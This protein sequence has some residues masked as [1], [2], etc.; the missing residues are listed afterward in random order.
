[1][2]AIC[3]RTFSRDA[4]ERFLDRSWMLERVAAPALNGHRSALDLLDDW[5]LRQRTATLT[6]ASASDVRALLSSS[7][8]DTVSRQCESPLGL[9][10]RFYQSLQDCKVR[11]DDPV[12]T[13]IDRE[14]AAAARKRDARPDVEKRHNRVLFS[15][16]RTV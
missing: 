16:P 4:I 2:S 9:L 12:E 7:Y 3:E 14:L 10:T 1:M 5:M 13:L 15:H 8:W 11:V 6:T